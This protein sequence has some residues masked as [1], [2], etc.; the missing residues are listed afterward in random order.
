MAA[1]T[2]TAANIIPV[3]GATI[4]TGYLAGATI[5]R[6]QGVYLAAANTWLLADSDLSAIAAG[7]LGFGIS[8]SD[9]GTGQYMQVFRG[10]DLGMGVC[11]T[12]GKVYC[13]NTVA[14]EIIAHAELASGTRVSI[15]GVATTTS[16]LSCRMWYT[17]ALAP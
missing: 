12:A 4:E 5:T 16:N 8:L 11:L 6:G 17:S 7:S 13:I 15:F 9:V 2:I 10:G 14:G 1:V 3:A